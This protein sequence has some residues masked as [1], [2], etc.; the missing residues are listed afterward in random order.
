MR[1]TRRMDVSSPLEHRHRNP[2]PDHVL[3]QR[4]DFLGS[5]TAEHDATG[6]GVEA[7]NLGHEA[8]CKAN[9]ADHAQRHFNVECGEG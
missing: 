5:E 3:D 4:N 1:L 8:T 2:W 7:D 9:P 6:M